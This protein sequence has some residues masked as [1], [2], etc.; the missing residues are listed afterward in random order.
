MKSGTGKVRDEDEARAG[1]G[2]G[3]RVLLEVF[4]NLWGV[5]GYLRIHA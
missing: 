5:K 1:G 3:V 2:G 4:L